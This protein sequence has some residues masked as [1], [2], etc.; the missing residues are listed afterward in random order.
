[1]K[2]VDR[3]GWAAG[4]CFVA[5][6]RRI[7][8][9]ANT[10]EV[11]ERLSDRLPCGWR[12]AASPVVDHVYSVVAGG[13]GP[14]AHIRRF[15]LVYAGA[16]QLARTL[17]L[18]EAL[19]L[20]ES[21]LHLHV[22]ARARGKLFVHAGVVGWRDRAIVIP[23]RTLAGKTTLV[24]ALVRAG[25]TYYSDEYAVLDASGR[26]HPYPKPLSI[27]RE[28]SQRPQRL[29]VEALGAAVGAKPLPV[30]LILLS[31]YRAGARWRPRRL[32]P[33]QAVLALLAE[34]VPAR[35]RP[36]AAIA[37]LGQVAT[38]APALRGMRGE[39]EELAHT[40]LAGGDA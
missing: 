21:D 4:M 7:G 37:R 13:N 25:A 34:T 9:R 31:R 33:G 28:G 16:M 15:H 26:V 40:L 3:L 17:D 38:Q 11:L 39:A 32:S 30:G 12:P 1:M 23:G 36:A 5:Y 29:P 8:I 22:A 14:Q 35:R 20:L 27:R 2:K 6:G 24:A 10:A 18:D 19:D